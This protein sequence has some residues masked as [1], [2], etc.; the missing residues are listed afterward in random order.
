MNILIYFENEFQNNKDNLDKLSRLRIDL[1]A[2]RL[3]ISDITE[4][5]YIKDLLE[6]VNKTLEYLKNNS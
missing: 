4:V 6:R 5:N 3:N 1:L 2:Q